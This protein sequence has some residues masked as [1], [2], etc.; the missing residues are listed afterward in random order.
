MKKN[1]KQIY[2]D[3]VIGGCL[4]LGVGMETVNGKRSF[5]GNEHVLKLDWID[6]YTTLNMLTLIKLYILNG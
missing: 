6:S 4:G 2:K 3:K 1:F 5:L